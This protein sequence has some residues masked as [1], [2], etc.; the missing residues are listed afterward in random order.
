MST[1]SSKFFAV[2][3]RYFS[4]FSFTKAMT[5]TH[6]PIL[7]IRRFTPHESDAEQSVSA[8]AGG[9]VQTQDKRIEITILSEEVDFLSLE[10]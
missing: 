5:G 10:H 9:H 6:S 4:S 8:T 7:T 2:S 1:K 3:R